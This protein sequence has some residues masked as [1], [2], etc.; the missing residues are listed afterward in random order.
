MI[1]AEYSLLDL[2]RIHV[3]LERLLSFALLQVDAR[4]IVLCVCHEHMPTSDNLDEHSKRLLIELQSLFEPALDPQ[5]LPHVVLGL[6]N[7]HVLL[8]ERSLLDFEGA[9]VVSE[10]AHVLTLLEVHVCAVHNRLGD[11]N[12]LAPKYRLPHLH[13]ARQPPK[14][15][16][17]D[18][19]QEHASLK[20]VYTEMRRHQPS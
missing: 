3:A 1:L 16:F 17:M 19:Q 8:P 18:H 13:T 5:S 2:E 9:R 20:R 10:G 15:K 14:Y 4:D 7:E 11:K 12:M 6:G